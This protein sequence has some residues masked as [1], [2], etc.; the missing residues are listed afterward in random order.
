[1]YVKPT[2]NP[3]IDMID[4][5]KN[6]QTSWNNR[7]VTN[8]SKNITT[9]PKKLFSANIT[10]CGSKYHHVVLILDESGS[11]SSERQKTINTINEFLT[12]IRKSEIDTYISMVT[13]DGYN[14]KWVKIK[15]N[16]KA[17]E[18]LTL[19]DYNPDGMT[20][21]TD[22]VCYVLDTL[23]SSMFLEN[24]KE[25]GA[26]S[27]FIVTDGEENSSV[28]YK[29]DSVKEMVSA[30]E[31]V[32]YAFRFFGADI[33][34]FSGSES[35]GVNKNATMTLSKSKIDNLGTVMANYTATRSAI[36]TSGST[37]VATAGAF[38]ETTHGSTDRE[39]LK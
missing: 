26:V 23:N 39:K 17:V 14:H 27:V 35:I 31:P 25:R 20:N 8:W 12:K 36:L 33:D 10:E 11:M 7:R 15:Q 37:S 21:L 16:V 6:N 29:K 22:T 9:Q 3:F 18:N 30:L 19:D 4:I 1:M 28:V 5:D 32:G 2:V 24:E 34:A 13:F 38:Y